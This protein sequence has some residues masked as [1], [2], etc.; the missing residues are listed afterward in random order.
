[1]EKSLLKLFSAVQ[2]EN[3]NKIN[4]DTSIL[5]RTI[6]NGYVLD[7]SIIPNEKQIHLFINHG[8]L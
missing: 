3:K 7:P 5:N 1:M 4:F 8:K 6:K 2:V